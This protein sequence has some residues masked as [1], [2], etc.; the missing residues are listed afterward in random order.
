MAVQEELAWQ[1]KDITLKEYFNGQ[2]KNKYAQ[3]NGY[4]YET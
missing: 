4:G 1:L 2:I 3:K